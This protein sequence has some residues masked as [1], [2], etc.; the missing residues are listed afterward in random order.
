MGIW[1]FY[2]TCRQSEL[3]LI[4]DLSHKASMSRTPPYF[5]YSERYKS[6]YGLYLM[7]TDGLEEPSEGNIKLR[8]RGTSTELNH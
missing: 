8:V 2:T 5:E 6:W 4:R 3:G 7:L 1:A